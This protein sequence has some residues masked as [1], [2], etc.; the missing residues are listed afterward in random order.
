VNFQ[1]KHTKALVLYRT[2][3]AESDRIV[4][5]LT[6]DYGKVRAI[7]KGVRKERGKLAAGVELFCVNEIGFITGRSELATLISAKLIKSYHHFLGDLDKVNFAY[8]SL[9]KL[10]KIIAE[11]ADS[12]YFELVEK[13]LAALDETSIGLDITAVWWQ[14]NL[15]QLTGH[16]LDLS[17]T[18]KGAKLSDKQIYTFDKKHGGFVEDSQGEFTPEHIKFLRLALSYVPRTLA[19][20]KGA[21][22]LANS[23]NRAMSR[24]SDYHYQIGV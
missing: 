1:P 8:D 12:Q 22:T 21:D 15:T 11:V 20:I 6:K 19:R 23:L 17:Q 24:F 5:F 16:G 14:V 10:N 7:A 18:V 13:L 4:T 2:N 3:Y 9:K